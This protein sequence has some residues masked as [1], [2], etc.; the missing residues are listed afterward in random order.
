M[1]RPTERDAR[2]WTAYGNFNAFL[3]LTQER[4]DE[5]LKRPFSPKNIGRGV[6]GIAQRGL[7]RLKEPAR[8]IRVDERV[9]IARDCADIGKG[10]LKLADR[11]PLVHDLA[12]NV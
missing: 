7:H 5:L 12:A 6:R 11:A 3:H 2:D 10:Q 1:H 8:L 9:D 4:G